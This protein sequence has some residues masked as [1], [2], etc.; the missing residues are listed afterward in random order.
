MKKYRLFYGMILVLPLMF[1]LMATGCDNDDYND[2]VEKSV[3]FSQLPD[4]AQSFIKEYFPDDEMEKGV[5]DIEDGVT[6]YEVT[7]KSGVE[8]DFNEKGIWQ[9]V[10]APYGMTLPEGFIL[11]PIID[12][13]NV[14]YQGYGI[15]E[16][17]RS[18]LGFKVE[19]IT[20]LELLFDQIGDFVKVIDED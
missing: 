10:D 14:N 17:N 6:I 7:L 8:I 19:L 1:G 16:I 20:G 5:K 2:N 18:G 3:S 4:E 15:N 13:L 9:Q 12:Y 11:E